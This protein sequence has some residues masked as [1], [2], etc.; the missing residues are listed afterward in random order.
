MAS[1]GALGN[2]LNTRPNEQAGVDVSSLGKAR[3]RIDDNT[4]NEDAG[5]LGF[6][7]SARRFLP[8]IFRRR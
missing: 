8:C 2:C 6:A 3:N 5:A 4:H 7:E 1:C